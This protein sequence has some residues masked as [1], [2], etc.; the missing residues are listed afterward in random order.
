MKGQLDWNDTLIT[1]F[2]VILF[3]IVT[4][5]GA[6]TLFDVQTSVTEDGKLSYTLLTTTENILEA[7]CA[8]SSRSVFDEEA[9][10]SGRLTCIAAD[11]VLL[12]FS[13]AQ[14]TQQQTCPRYKLSNTGDSQEVARI[15]RE[16]YREERT[17]KHMRFPVTIQNRTGARIPAVMEV[18]F[19]S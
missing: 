13:T 15:D 7:P 11:G 4:V 5:I 12:R 19:T 16:T 2:G 3:V 1:I 8:T 9:V 14:C 17:D 10:A 6:N 18:G